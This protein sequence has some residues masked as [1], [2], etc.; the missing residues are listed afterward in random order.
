MYEPINA[1]PPSFGEWNEDDDLLM[2][3]QI[4]WDEYRRRQT[5]IYD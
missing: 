5:K 3:G 4:D 2:S 1:L